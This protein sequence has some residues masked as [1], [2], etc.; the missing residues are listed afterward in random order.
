MY[1]RL[2]QRSTLTG[3]AAT[4]FVV[5]VV[6]LFVALYTGG[7]RGIGPLWAMALVVLAATAACWFT[8]AYWGE[9][10]ASPPPNDATSA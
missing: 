7:G 3:M 5:G 6:M 10:S 2:R 9:E 8:A 1:K 4:L